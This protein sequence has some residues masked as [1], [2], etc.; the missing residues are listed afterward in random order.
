MI[1]RSST[2]ALP[3]LKLILTLRPCARMWLPWENAVR[4]ARVSRDLT[5]ETDDC[6]ATS[7]VRTA[8]R[9]IRTEATERRHRKRLRAAMPGSEPEMPYAVARAC[10]AVPRR[11]DLRGLNRERAS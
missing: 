7:T 10:L 5:S 9:S 8:R 3:A 1:L 2:L 6:H 11:G 4:R